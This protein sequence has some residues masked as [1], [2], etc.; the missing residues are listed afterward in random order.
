MSEKKKNPLDSDEYPRTWP[1]YIGQEPA[2]RMLA[3]AAKAAKARKKPMGHVLIDHPTGGVGK[4]A[5]G[6]LTARTLGAKKIRFISGPLGKDAARMLLSDLDDGD[7]V[8]Y[9]EAHQ[10]MD[11]GRRNMEWA[12][13]YWQDGVIAGP[14]GPE[15][16]PL[17]TFICCTTDGHVLPSTLVGRFQFRPPMQDYTT[18]EA[19]K[20]AVNVADQVLVPEEMPTL[21]RKDALALA[22]ASHNN[23]RA[24]RKLLETMRDMILAGEAKLTDRGTYPIGELLEFSG[25]T[26]DGLD[27]DAQR[28]LTTLAYQFGGHAG[29]KN[30]EDHILRP[31]GLREVERLLMDKGFLGK[32]RTGRELTRDGI[33]RARQLHET[34]A[35]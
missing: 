5:L 20:I 32:T 17:V 13:S 15:A 27:R 29:A 3:V 14:M 34:V 33:T 10:L 4:T 28:Y 18:P 22:V 9:D 35:A 12:L 19:A 26:P 30:L 25:V 23:P 16:F 24:M 21:A 1:K 7:A 2:K 8:V 11:K 31:G 6:I